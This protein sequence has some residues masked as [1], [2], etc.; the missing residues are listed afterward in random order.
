MKRFFLRILCTTLALGST[1]LIAPASSAAA[2]KVVRT[3]V[4]IYGD[5]DE[6]VTELQTALKEKGYFKVNV[7]GYYGSITQ[8]AVMDFQED[9]KI[10]VDGKA[11]PVTRKALLG[12][13]YKDLPTTRKVS[14]ATAD[15]EIETLR[16]QSEG[17]AV[18]KLQKKLKELGYYQYSRI[19]GFFG[20]IT[21]TAVRDF[22]RANGLAV[23]GLAGVKTQGMLYSGNAKKASAASGSSASAQKQTVAKDKVAT[24]IAN[25]KTHLGKPYKWGGNGPS[26]F[27]CSGYVAYLLKQMGK[28]TPRTANDMSLNSNWTKV[29]YQNLQAGDL[30][31]FDTRGGNPPVGHV[32]IY[33]GD[34]QFIHSSSGKGKVVISQMSSGYYKTHFKWGRRVF[35][36]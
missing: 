10:T 4:L 33:I 28:S 2:K 6:Y 13:D 15:D 3:D 26:S 24:L 5:E 35:E 16:V 22:Q 27:D 30:V 1:V 7:T 31:F 20:P 29:S 18:T 8:K 23:D 14:S 32:G 34:G 12:S 25:A 9:A 36:N 19:T 11:G 17:E 21:E